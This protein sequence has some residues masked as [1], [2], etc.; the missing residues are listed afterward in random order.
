MPDQVQ[1]R[2]KIDPKTGPK[3]EV[4]G[5]VWRPEN[6]GFGD[7]LE[8]VWDPNLLGI[9]SLRPISETIWGLAGWSLGPPLKN[10][11]KLELKPRAPE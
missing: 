9:L 4:W 2:L 1:N 11:R 7:A 5:S 3:P 8:K 6:Q 10:S